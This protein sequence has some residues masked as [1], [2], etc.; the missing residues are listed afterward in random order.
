MFR[1]KK[2]AESRLA[3][4]LMDDLSIDAC[5]A[6]PH[7]IAGDWFQKFRAARKQFMRALDDS[8]QELAML[9]LAREDFMA[10]LMGQRLPENLTIRFRKPILYGGEIS[11][12]NMF[13]MPSYPIGLNLDFFMIEQIGQG[14]I[15]YP[16]P[17]KKVY[18]SINMISGTEGG[19]AT[20]DRL[21]QG[22][23]AMSH[24]R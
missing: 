22:F 20:S 11:A 14:E 12:D 18:I 8:I 21:A 5:A 10:L 7:P 15:W 2:E 19:N 6:T 9:N 16:N 24:D 1:T 17:A 13:M 4:F 3:H 23:A